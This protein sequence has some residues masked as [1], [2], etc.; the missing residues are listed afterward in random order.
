ME[1]E[2]NQDN[3][4]KESAES[5]NMSRNMYNKERDEVTEQKGERPTLMSGG[6]T[7]VEFIIDLQN[8]YASSF[9]ESSKRHG[10][11]AAKYTKELNAL[12]SKKQKKG[13]E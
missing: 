3:Y 7:S 12:R 2:W 4:A 9:K 6:A 10:K 8:A 5:A 13:S 11:N 1:A